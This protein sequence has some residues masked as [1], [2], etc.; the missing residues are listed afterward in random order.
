MGVQLRW[1]RWLVLAALLAACSNRPAVPTP[2]PT[3]AASAGPTVGTGEGG[4]GPF[5]TVGF[6]HDDTALEARLPTVV[7]GIALTVTSFDATSE[8]TGDPA[9]ER[10]I[11]FLAT[12][13]RTAADLKIAEAFDP[14]NNAITLVAW[15]APGVDA[16][17]L[18]NSMVLAGLFVSKTA[19]PPPNVPGSTTVGG[20]SVV[21]IPQAG[22]EVDDLYASGDVLIDV[23]T[24]DPSLAAQVLGGLS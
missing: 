14:V 9:G 2:G 15:Q 20:K 4:S 11:A 21:Q 18:M 10:L 12:Q 19:S 3:L 24:N 8:L 22:G 7:N 13:G 5:P 23:R 6:H 16:S 1:G 17:A